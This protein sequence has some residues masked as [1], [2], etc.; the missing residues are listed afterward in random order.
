M[1]QYEGIDKGLFKEILKELKK[2][3]SKAVNI[4]YPNLTKFISK[5]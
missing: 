1:E 3:A 4:L 2:K 5:I